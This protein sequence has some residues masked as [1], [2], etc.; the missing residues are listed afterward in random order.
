[1]VDGVRIV[2]LRAMVRA[3]RKMHLEA[4]FSQEGEDRILRRFFEGRT[5][6]F[7]LDVGALH[8]VRFSNTLLL[9]LAG[10]RGVNIDATPGSMRPF[11][12]LRP[13]DI[14]LEV[15]I[16]VDPGVA[17]FYVFREPALNTFDADL[18]EERRAKGW[19]FKTVIPLPRRRLSEV[20][21]ECVPAGVV[22]DLLTVDVEGRDIDVLESLD[23]ARQR[24][25]V[26]CVE[27]LADSRLGSF[28]LGALDDRGY[29]LVAR[30]VNTV[31]CARQDR[32][33]D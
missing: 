24:P 27:Q 17:N 8:P 4:S 13:R 30:T 19:E 20:W 9:Y 31:L 22:V 10:W 6:G 29:E 15:A 7:Y 32:R 12:S 5:A 14:N 1:M 18:A 11:R 28:V 25:G 21:D 26:V 16:G 2:G 3:M 23:W 33:D